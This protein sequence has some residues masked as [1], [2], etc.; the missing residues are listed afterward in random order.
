[1]LLQN[2]CH[3]V[4]LSAGDAAHLAMAVEKVTPL[5]EGDVVNVSFEEWDGKLRLIFPQPVNTLCLDLEN[6]SHLGWRARQFSQKNL[7]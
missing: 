1:M 5:T 3:W 4:A 2:M 7:N 6:L